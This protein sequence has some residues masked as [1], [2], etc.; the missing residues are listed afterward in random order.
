MALDPLI[1]DPLVDAGELSA[2]LSALNA[3][4]TTRLL[5]PQIIRAF[6]F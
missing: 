3:V 6:I 1:E 4:T 5:G 2:G